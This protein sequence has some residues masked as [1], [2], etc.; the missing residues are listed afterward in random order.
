MRSK[1]HWGDFPFE[2]QSRLPSSKVISVEL[3]GIGEESHVRPPFSLFG[4]A[5]LV[6]EKVSLEAPGGRVGILG[7]SL[8]GMVALELMG[9]FPKFYKKAMLVNSSSTLSPKT[10]RLRWQVWKDVLAVA[11]EA[12]KVRREHK[13]IPHLVNSAEGQKKMAESWEK[14]AKEFQYHPLTPI[15]QLRAA[16][17]FL[18]SESLKES[19]EI[20]LIRSMGDLFVD[21]SCSELMSRRFSWEMH[22]HPWAGH[23]LAWDDPAWL[24]GEIESFFS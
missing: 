4:I 18:P 8:G 12:N 23:D 24:L 11:L 3:P 5:Q 1:K 9:A 21:P 13:V 15:A 16:S 14:V 20:L 10:K 7:V 22:D 2:V 19:K 17:G 6:H